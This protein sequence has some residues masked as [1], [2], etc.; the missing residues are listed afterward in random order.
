MP[1]KA[2]FCPNCLLHSSSQDSK[3]PDSAALAQLVRAPDCGSGGPPFEPGRWYHSPDSLECLVDGSNLWA[4]PRDRTAHRCQLGLRILPQW[5]LTHRQTQE[6][7]VLT[8]SAAAAFE[9]L[10]TTVGM[11]RDGRGL[12]FCR[13]PSWAAISRPVG[14]CISCPTGAVSRARFTWSGRRG[15]CSVRGPR[16]CARK[17]SGSFG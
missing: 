1:A 5:Q 10:V 6:T 13:C 17:W 3:S 4:V 2:P 11:A 9:D 7:R 14:W 16:R 12:R 8:L 15:V